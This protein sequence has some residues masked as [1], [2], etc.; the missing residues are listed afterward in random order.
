[1]N[2]VR[3]QTFT[4]NRNGNWDNSAVWTRSNYCGT[5][6][7]QNQT[8]VNYPSPPP[9]GGY[10]PQCPVDIVINHTVNFNLSTEFG[11]GYFR[12]ITVNTG[13]R[14][15]FP[16]NFILAT[17]GSN[18]SAPNNILRITVKNGGEISVPGGLFKVQR[19]ALITVENGGKLTVKDME[20]GGGNG[21]TVN[22]NAGASFISTN[23]VNL[24][25][26][27]RINLSGSF[28]GNM[29]TSDGGGNG[30]SILGNASFTTSGDVRINEFPF[31]A[32]GSSNVTIGGNLNVTNSGGSSL[33]INDNS[34]FI[35]EGSTS[36]NQAVKFNGNSTATF[37]GN[38]AI[39][40]SGGS[41]LELN[42]F[43]DVLITGNLTK[44]QYSGAI[45]VRNSGQ[46]VICNDRR[47]NG[48]IEGSYPPVSH[49]NMNIAPSPAYYGGCRILP[50][51][52]RYFNTT[53][54]PSSH[55]ALLEWSTAKEW[56][57]SHFEIERA[58]NDIKTWTAIGKV[59]G[60]GYTDL[61]VEYRFED[62][63]LPRSGGN[64]FYR[65]KQVD[66]NGNFTYSDTKAI[67][68]TPLEGTSAWIVYP[69][70]SISGQPVTV[71]IQD[72]N[73]FKDEK[74]QVVISDIRGVS[75]SYSVSNPDEVSAYVVD[76]L[77][78]AS[79]G[80]HVVQLIWGGQSQ[81][82]KVVRN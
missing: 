51:D 28:T 25:N 19:D 39:G 29:I 58:I 5:A 26:G 35:V 54:Q 4:S 13:G 30:I 55:T 57:S 53:Y 56:Q 48:T 45:T 73:A 82:L 78:Q 42:S 11:A 27:L 66:L 16:N 68:V 76:Y 52:Y 8:N 49:S 75:K 3:A 40:S 43:A 69:N 22:I 46:L 77:H 1:M 41:L 12:S 10:Y 44:P 50:V 23:R 71:T 59:E 64:V 2:G 67:Q 65:L 79:S 32:S 24:N 31:V 81:Q 9:T 21:G 63:D 80:I 72:T 36:I 70:P 61:P 37:N 20:G 7:Q 62:K 34:N 14:L 15:V 74:I 60:Q 33:T 47:P 17:S 6:S 18:L 38:V